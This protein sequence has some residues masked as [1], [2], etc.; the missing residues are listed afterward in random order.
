VKAQRGIPEGGYRVGLGPV[1]GAKGGRA[2]NADL[3]GK[4]THTKRTAHA[5]GWRPKGCTCCAE[6]RPLKTYRL[7]GADEE[8]LHL[9]ASCSIEMRSEVVP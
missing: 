5:Q 4:S 9:C 8:E 2:V 6:E 7:L 3:C 1:S